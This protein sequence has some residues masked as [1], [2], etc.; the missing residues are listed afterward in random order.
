MARRSPVSRPRRRPSP[1]APPSPRAGFRKTGF[2][3]GMVRLNDRV[4]QM[5]GYAQ[6]TSIEWPAVGL[7]VPPWL[8]DYSNGLA[9]EGNANLTRSPAPNRSG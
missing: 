9:V 8:S 1:P 3:D 6:R 4:L 7:S 2:G 5:K